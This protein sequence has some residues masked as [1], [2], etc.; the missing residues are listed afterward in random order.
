MATR[1]REKAAKRAEE[2]DLR[3][4]AVARHIRMSPFKIRQVL[5]I[6]RGKD[7]LEAVAILTATPRAAAPV[8]KKLIN[9]AAANAENNLNLSKDDLMVAEIF[10]DQGPSLKRMQ[11]RAKGSAYRIVKRTSHI[12]V[13]LAVK[14][15]TDIVPKKSAK[16]SVTKAKTSSSKASAPKAKATAAKPV[17]TKTVAPKA[18]TSETK[19]AAA[20]PKAAGD[21]AVEAKPKTAEGKPKTAEAKPKAADAKPKITEG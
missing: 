6:I 5:D 13:V 11:M 21:K 15:K 14:E 17:A 10:A 7:Y 12:T 16:T 3:P 19:P 2:K 8:V 4:R 1:I 18:K 20:K 9:S